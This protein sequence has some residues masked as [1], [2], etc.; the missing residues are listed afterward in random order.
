MAHE[1]PDQFGFFL[2]DYQPPGQFAQSRLYAGAAQI[3]T[4]STTVAT[5][6]GFFALSR[7]GLSG[8][9]NGFGSVNWS[10]QPDVGDNSKS[11]G[12]LGYTEPSSDSTVITQNVADMC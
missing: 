4:F 12:Y 3:L 5:T 11:V 7:N 9:N 8:W 6:E 2:T 10:G 1:S